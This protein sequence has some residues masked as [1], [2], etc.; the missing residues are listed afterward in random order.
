MCPSV[1]S[2][3]SYT[4]GQETRHSATRVSSTEEQSHLCLSLGLSPSFS[5]VSSIRGQNI[6]INS[7]KPESHLHP[8]TLLLLLKSLIKYFCFLCITSVFND[9]SQTEFISKQSTCQAGDPAMIPGS[10]RCPGEGNGNPLQY[11]CLGNPMDRGAWQATIY[12]VTKDW[13]TT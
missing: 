11:S 1:G 6:S 9:P 2:P 5:I 8:T 4:V 13:G 3:T 12:G 7:K 10:G